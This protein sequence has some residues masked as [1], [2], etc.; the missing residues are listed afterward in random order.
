MITLYFSFR[1]CLKEKGKKNQIHDT[2]IT[3]S[4]P[5]TEERIIK[6]GNQIQCSDCVLN[7]VNIHSGLYSKYTRFCEN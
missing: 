3:I 5:D 4:V 6:E 7:V 1:F 2:E